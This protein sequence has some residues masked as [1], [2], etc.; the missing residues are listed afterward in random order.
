MKITNL[1]EQAGI[2]LQKVVQTVPTPAQHARIVFTIV[3]YQDA[4]QLRRLVEAIHMPHHL[5]VIHLEQAQAQR[6]DEFFKEMSDIASSYSNVVIVQFG[7]VIYKTDS[8][9]RINL[10]LMNWVVNDLKLDYDYHITLGGAVYPLYGASELARHL[11]SSRG[12]SVWLGEMTHKGMRVHHPQWGVLWKKRVMTTGLKV[13]GRLKFIFGN[14][15]PTWMDAV[16]QHKTNSG[17]QATFSMTTVKRMLEN[18]QIQNIFALAKYGC[19]CCIEERTWVAAMD[20]LGLLDEAK[21]NRN[22]FQLWGG[23]PNRCIGTISNAVLDMNETRCFRNESP[24]HKDLYVWGNSTWENLV[25]AKQQGV[26]FARKFHSNHTGS[27]HLME[28]IRRVLHNGS[29]YRRHA[30]TLLQEGPYIWGGSLLALGRTLI[31]VP[32]RS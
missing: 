31:V 26:L 19:C 5:I 8:V 22:M 4:P 29:P 23:D 3:A 6:D 25:Q 32:L 11:Y 7:T 14:T 18:Q 27:V 16:L 10:Q 1:T 20:I 2:Q 17:N 9:S 12:R 28:Q 13:E 21:E 15:V 30:L 24:G